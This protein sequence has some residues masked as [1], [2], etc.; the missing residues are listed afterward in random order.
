MWHK[1]VGAVNDWLKT[2]SPAASIAT[3]LRGSARVSLPVPAY[4]AQIHLTR[5]PPLFDATSLAR[6]LPVLVP[7]I[8]PA[9][10]S[11]GRCG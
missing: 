2:Q 1:L 5:R 4:T 3:T 11:R 10:S 8:G 9:L 6:S 7:A